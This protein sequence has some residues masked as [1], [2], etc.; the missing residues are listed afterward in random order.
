MFDLQTA[1]ADEIMDELTE[2]KE[3]IEAEGRKPTDSERELAHLMLVQFDKRVAENENRLKG[4]QPCRPSVDG[5]MYGGSKVM[6]K[7]DLQPYELR[8]PGDPKDHKSMFGEQ[9][10][11]YLKW[12]DKNSNF[13]Q[14][15]FSGR[16][17]PEL[18][19]GMTESVQSGGGFLVPTEY[20]RT[21]HDVALENEIVQPLAYVRPMA[22]NEVFV[23]S[24]EIGNHSDSLYGGFTASYIEETGTISKTQPKIRGVELKAKKLTG[25]IRMSNELIADMGGADRIMQICGRG[26]GWYH[27]RA[28]LKGSGAGEP[29]GV[30][31]SPCLITQNKETSQ[32]PDTIV[33]ENLTKMVSRLYSGSFKNSVWIAHQ[34]TIPQLLQLGLAVGTGGS[35]VPVLKE[36][37]G[38]F[39]M[40]TRPVIFTEKTEVLG[41]KGDI[42]LADFSQYIIGLRDG[43]RMDVSQHVHFDTDESLGRL[44]ERHDGQPLWNKPLKLEDGATTVSPFV[45]LQARA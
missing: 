37:D 1:Q 39:S 42:L 10:N 26:L 30:L 18:Q 11:N 40:L 34:S 9:P 20:E 4:Y 32:D 22:S 44:I 8:S 16:M 45:T 27:D 17:H 14:A 43:L 2:M 24:M 35:A 33:Y 6:H 41:D 23:P 7:R 28:F 29:L 13:F 31:N 38:S 12:N 15:L 36:S 19:R 25:L 21:I 3:R 5:D